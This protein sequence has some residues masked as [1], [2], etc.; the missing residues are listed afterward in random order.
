MKLSNHIKSLLAA[1][2]VSSACVAHA[3][4]FVST[5]VNT[6]TA[7]NLDISWVWNWSAA[8]FLGESS[9]PA[10]NYWTADAFGWKQSSPRGAGGNVYVL[11]VA[12]NHFPIG[13]VDY[14]YEAGAFSK[15]A[16]ISFFDTATVNGR[17]YNLSIVTDPGN[18]SNWNVHLTGVAPVP[19]PGEWALMLSGIG[20]IGFMIRRRASV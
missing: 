9:A 12:A 17:T 19:E 14:E 8:S 5:T 16:N 18:S 1:V 13:G 7:T 3:G 20:L 6:D 2:A 11:D 15:V 4:S 10:L